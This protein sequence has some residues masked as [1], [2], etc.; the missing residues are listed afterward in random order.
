MACSGVIRFQLRIPI[1]R[2]MSFDNVRNFCDP[3]KWLRRGLNLLYPFRCPWCDTLLA[4]EISSGSFGW[5]QLCSVCQKRILPQEKISCLRCGAFFSLPK[6]GEG[7]EPSGFAHR[8]RHGCIHCTNDFHYFRRVVSLGE[9]R[10]EFREVILRMKNETTGNLATALAVLLFRNRGNEIRSL[11]SDCVIPVPMHYS[12]RIVRGVNNPDFLAEELGRRLKIPVLANLVCR[13]RSTNVQYELT[14]KQRANNVKKA[15]TL[16]LG[17]W[18]HFRRMTPQTLLGGKNIL[19]VDDILTSGATLNE[20]A[21]LLTENG[22]ASVNV[23]VF[24]RAV[25]DQESSR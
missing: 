9:Y 7:E 6:Q 22:A 20:I 4:D 18:R 1:L 24:A 13:T 16:K 23:C 3:E 15:F 17:F 25:G 21:R 14:P 19:L 10:E 2:E 5:T 8:Q 12:R 11:H